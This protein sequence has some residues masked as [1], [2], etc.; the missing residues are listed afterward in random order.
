M[1]EQRKEINYVL[2]CIIEFSRKYDITIKQ[3]FDYL[4]Q[5]K[6]IEFLKENYD[7]EH[8]LSLDDALDDMVL[9]CQNNGGNLE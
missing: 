1:S 4:F 9:I 5:Y 8:T 7:I 2:A 3:A 6:A